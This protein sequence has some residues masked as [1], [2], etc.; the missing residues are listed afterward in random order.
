MYR[1]RMVQASTM[2]WMDLSLNASGCTLGIVARDGILL[3]DLPRVT[4]H[5]VMSAANRW[6]GF[7]AAFMPAAEVSLLDDDPC[8]N[9]HLLSSPLSSITHHPWCS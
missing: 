3:R 6:A 5:V 7:L 2:K 8:Y 9:L 1:W 4:D